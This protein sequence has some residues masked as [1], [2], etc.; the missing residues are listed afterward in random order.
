MTKYIVFAAVTATLILG[1]VFILRPKDQISIA[2]VRK[3]FRCDRITADVLATDIYC[4]NPNY[5]YEDV[6]NGTIIDAAD[7]DDPRYRARY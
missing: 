6:K 1:A 7:F 3:K 5:Y 2:E 4:D